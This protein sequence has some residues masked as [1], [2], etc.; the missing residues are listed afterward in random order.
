MLSNGSDSTPVD[1]KEF[2]HAISEDLLNSWSPILISCIVALIFSYILLVL[3]RYAIKYV[4]WVI[5]IGLIVVL[6]IGAI[7]F[8]VLYFKT[9]GDP[10]STPEG[11]LIAAG[12]SAILAVILG[13][14]IFIFRKRIALVVQIFKEA[15]K[16]L[17]DVPLIVAEPLL[18]FLAMG[19]ATATFLYFVLVIQSSGNLTV[20]NDKN[21]QFFKATY[22]QDF[23]SVAAF[24]INLVSYIWFTQFIL[25]CQHFVI[26]GTVC[27]WFFSHTKTKL[28][29]PIKRS[30]HQLLRIHIG[31]ICLGSIFITLVKIIRMLVD[32]LTV[33]RTQLNYP[34]TF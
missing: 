24:Y 30:F 29:S 12:V 15:S 27:Q 13:I 19:L 23:G 2:L 33:S 21:G 31:S 4:I 17:A 9:K 1:N 22:E 11:F 8:L 34:L 18:T 10:N 32:S 14:V 20:Q 16:V 3:F 7:V 5:Y 25:G 26:A 6:V 28:A